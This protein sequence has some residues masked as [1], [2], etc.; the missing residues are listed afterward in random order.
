MDRPQPGS[1]V[2][3][4]AKLAHANP[5]AGYKGPLPGGFPVKMRHQIALIVLVCA[6]VLSSHPALA[7]FSQQGPKLVGTGAVGNAFQ[8]YS[9][10]LSA[11]GNTAI[12]GGHGDNNCA[13]AAWVWRR[14]AG[15]W[16]QQGTKLVGS[17]AVGPYPSQ[18][19]SVS[20]SADGNTAIVGGYADNNGVGGGAAWVWT[21]TAGVWT[22]Q[23]AKLVGSG[24]SM[25][26]AQGYSVSLSADGNTAIVGGFGD[27]NYAGAA[28]VWTRSGGVWTQQGSKLV[29]SGASGIAQQGDSVSISADGNTA[30]VGGFGDNNYAGAAWVWTRSGGVWTQQGSKLVGSGAVGNA[31]QGLSVSLSGDGNTALV[32]G[33]GDNNN[34]GAVWVWTRSGAVWTQQGTK[35][36]GTGTVGSSQQGHSV[37]LAAD[38]NKAIVGVPGT[39]AWVWMRSGGDWTEQ[40]SKLVG[41]G[42]VGYGNEGISVALS[43]DGSTTLVGG[44]ADNSGAGAAWVF[45]APPAAGDACY[46]QN[47]AIQIRDN[48]RITLNMSHPS[49]VNDN[50]FARLNIIDTANGGMAQ[51]SCYL[52]APCRPTWL[53]PR[54]LNCMI[55]LAVTYTYGVT[56][57]AGADHSVGSYHYDGRAMDVYSINGV[58]VNSGNPYVNAFIQGCYNMGAGYAFLEN[59][60]HIHAQWNDNGGNVAPSCAPR[61]SQQG[62]KLVGSDTTGQSGQGIS[63][64]ISADGNTAIVGGYA[65]NPDGAG[66]TAG[67]AWIWTRSGGVW[68]QQGAKLVGTGAV[69]NALQGYSVSLSADG[70]T[71]VVGGF[72]DNSSAGAAWIWTR[73]GGVWT[74]QGAKL[75]GSGT[76]GNAGQG[77]SVSL[78]ADGNTAAVGG[79]DDNSNAGAAWVWTRNEGVW[80]QQGT[81]LVGSGAVGKA[82]QGYSVSLSA[83][84]NT[85]IVGGYADNS[86][87]GAA[88]VWTR[89]GGVWTQQG[90]KLVGSGAVGN[91]VSQG[92]SVALSADGNT[93]IVGGYDDNPN[94][95]NIG[96]G[97]AWIWTWSGGIWSQQ[98]TKLVGSGAVGNA[99]QGYSVSL[100]ADGNT[101]IVSGPTDNADDTVH[102]TG[103]AWVWT[104]TAGVWAQQGGK[105][106]GADAV[107]NAEQ[108]VSVSLSADGST[109]I[110]GGFGDNSYAGAAWV[111]AVPAPA[112]PAITAQPASVFRRAGENATFS[113]TA[114]GTSPLRYQWHDGTG[115]LPNA[116]DSSLTIPKAQ[117][118][119]SYYVVVSNPNGSVTSQ[120]AQL[121]IL[122]DYTT[123]VPA[124]VSPTP[125]PPPPKPPSQHNLVIVTHGWQPIGVPQW[126]Y[127]MTDSI[128]NNL[129]DSTWTVFALSWNGSDGA[130]TLLPQTAASRSVVIGKKFGLGI[131]AQGWSHVHFIG[132]SAGA[133]LIQSAAE[134]L[135]ANSP[136]PVVVHTTFLDPYDWGPFNGHSRFGA[137]S[138]W[139]DN[140]FETDP[141]GP[142]TGGQMDHSY[143]VDISGLDQ[144]AFGSHSFAYEFYQNTI[145]GYPNN[146]NE[147]RGF[148]LSKEGG[149]WDYA[150]TTYQRGDPP[151]LLFGGLQLIGNGSGPIQNYTR[152]GNFGETSLGSGTIN[153]SSTGF[154][155][156]TT[157]NSP[158]KSKPSSANAFGSPVWLSL[159]ITVTNLV[160]FVK[161]D[162]GFTSA[163]NA[164]G[165]LTVYWNTNEIGMAD[166][167]VTTPGVQ[168]YSF[169]LPATYS[170]GNYVLG[171]RL[172]SFTNIVS[173]ISI[174]NVSLGY[175]GLT[176]TVTLGL[177]RAGGTNQLTLNGPPNYNYLVQFSSNLVDWIPAAIVPNTNGTA[178]FN[179]PAPTNPSQRFYR[180]I[181]P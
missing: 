125:P 56:E 66:L 173:S 178:L 8:G 48:S 49:G 92:H 12:V 69:G 143:N 102:G 123:A 174:T 21:R 161:F 59:N 104:R 118:D 95:S 97:G 119:G 37:S 11:D 47:L 42:A 137:G 176:N 140:Y 40:E 2:R 180:A 39:G 163:T 51:C 138:D 83:D 146:L 62:P 111:F 101:A 160:N 167:T 141:S 4:H 24:G 153:M 179:D 31:S 96:A 45:T 114:S 85:A 134:A 30:I 34:A 5:I 73:S 71:A 25:F 36:I 41:S 27:N 94:G 32:G 75:V 151:Y 105:L 128:G 87:A 28:W 14:S 142:L 126:I 80:S 144:S 93:A 168:T 18:G 127:D 86:N 10:S 150:T 162:A 112:V 65:D 170:S 113:V 64:A 89:T 52:T 175:A 133:V 98:G 149:H 78:S 165:L 156:F 148:L 74:Q 57:L 129:P 33:D 77:I 7:Q 88:W 23:G 117:A 99:L 19:V 79:Y 22:Q 181:S 164:A 155:M 15:V 177:S 82:L 136:S 171:F 43:A 55:Q 54:M 60:D 76:V 132:H 115:I 53:D 108:G 6:T 106:V 145:T 103:A 122:V 38:G 135:M 124:P 46:R 16:A 130:G 131:S 3:G 110:V 91:A 116:T 44:S 67:A 121:K 100:S 169:A 72:L 172:D 20:L 158:L 147:G 84:G 120:S 63:V 157:I 17:D 68:T 159:G 1:H 13:G 90:P 9:V 50:A 81:K 152:L 35:L 70:N 109:A 107:G 154:D 29:G 26:A 139:S 166:E 58:T 61:F